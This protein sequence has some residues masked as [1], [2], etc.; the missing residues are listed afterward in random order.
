MSRKQLKANTHAI[1]SLVIVLIV[2]V[3]VAS[4][5]G[6][7]VVWWLLDGSVN[8]VTDEMEFSDFVVVEVDWAFEVG[9]LNQVRIVIFLLTRAQNP[10]PKH[11]PSF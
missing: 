7:V 1:S 11:I 5:V 6:A 9:L 8:L 3:V 4:V 2:I 10:K